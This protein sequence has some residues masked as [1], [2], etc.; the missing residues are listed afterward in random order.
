MCRIGDRGI[1]A[2]EEMHSDS[3][4]A[5]HRKDGN[6]YL[7]DYSFSLIDTG[8]LRSKL[9]VPSKSL[10]QI[11]MSMHFVAQFAWG[12]GKGG[13]KLLPKGRYRPVLSVGKTSRSFLHSHVLYPLCIVGFASFFVLWFSPAFPICSKLF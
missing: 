4:P 9:I 3:L 12:M 11:S 1:Q 13:L 2:E 7:E 5:V 10:Y 6:I 8:S